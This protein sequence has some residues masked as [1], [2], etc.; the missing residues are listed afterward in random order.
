MASPSCSVPPQFYVLSFS[1]TKISSR[2]KQNK[3]VLKAM[4]PLLQIA[5][6]TETALHERKFFTTPFSLR[7]P[8]TA[9]NSCRPRSLANP[10]HKTKAKHL[11]TPPAFLERARNRLPIHRLKRAKPKSNVKRTKIHRTEANLPHKATVSQ[12]TR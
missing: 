5:A 11:R 8:K 2:A 12:W 9:T 3:Y 4:I 1:T 6:M 10:V 7:I